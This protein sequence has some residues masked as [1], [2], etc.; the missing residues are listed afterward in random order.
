MIAVIPALLLEPHSRAPRTSEIAGFT[1]KVNFSLKRG[2]E[3]GP[4][5]PFHVTFVFVVQWDPSLV[6]HL[7]KL[8][9]SSFMGGLRGSRRAG[10]LLRELCEFGEIRPG[11]HRSAKASAWHCLQ[12]SLMKC[13][14]SSS[15][16]AG[17]LRVP[18][19]ANRQ[20]ARWPVVLKV[21]GSI[22]GR[23][24]PQCWGR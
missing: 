21:A 24:R 12:A 15:A 10:G 11:Y 19:S 9:S 5:A 7:L 3:G 4:H 14:Y 6:T 17:I 16:F 8:F 1:N 2:G 13:G 18:A 22:P 23:E 20:E